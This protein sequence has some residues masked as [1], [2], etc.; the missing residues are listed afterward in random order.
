[1]ALAGPGHPPAIDAAGGR[2]RALGWLDRDAVAAALDEADIMV[3]PSVSEGLPVALLEARAHGTAVVATRVGGIPE[4]ITDGVDGVL[5]AP[6]DPAALARAIAQL[7]SDPARRARLA[8]AA[9]ESAAEH[10]G[11][12]T[13]ERL[14][15]LYRELARCA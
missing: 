9:R 12:D 10:G 2:V 7:A 8:R 14:D 4:A 6:R 5:V 1:V 3:L 11:E 15:G 13:Y